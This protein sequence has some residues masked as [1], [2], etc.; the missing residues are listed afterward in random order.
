VEDKIIL[1]TIRTNNPMIKDIRN[2][3]IIIRKLVR[4]FGIKKIN[5]IEEDNGEMNFIY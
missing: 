1:K 3:E 4:T 5:I 2:A